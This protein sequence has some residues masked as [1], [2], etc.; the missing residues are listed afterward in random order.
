MGC[1]CFPVGAFFLKSGKTAPT[2]S[3]AN[4]NGAEPQQ[5]QLNF[6]TCCSRKRKSSAFRQW[7]LCA[8]PS[9]DSVAEAESLGWEKRVY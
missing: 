7:H 5:N 2:L 9:G 8:L 1:S 3:F 4:C 6:T